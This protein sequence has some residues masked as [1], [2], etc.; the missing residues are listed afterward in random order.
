MPV[1]QTGL[2]EKLQLRATDSQVSRH[3]PFFRWPKLM[4]VDKAGI[5]QAAVEGHDRVARFTCVVASVGAICRKRCHL[6]LRH[7]KKCFACLLMSQR[8]PLAVRPSLR[9]ALTG[10]AL[11]RDFG[12]LIV[13]DAVRHHSCRASTVLV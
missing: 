12:A 10:D 5:Y 4:S 2:S 3:S 9:E 7:F 1:R 6:P 11:G 13:V 8:L